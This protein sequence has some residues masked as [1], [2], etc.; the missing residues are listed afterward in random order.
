MKADKNKLAYIGAKPGTN[1]Q[2]I[3]DSDAWFTPGIYTEMAR[4]VMGEI[5]LDPF[6]SAA[7][8]RHVK[9]KRYFDI[10]S[11]AFEKVWFQDQGRVFMN[12]PYGRKLINASVDI[13]LENW[14][15]KSILQAVVLVNNATETKWFQSLLRS[16]NSLCMP[17]RR[18]SF[19]A[20]DGKNVSGNTRGQVFFYFGNKSSKFKKVFKSVGVILMTDVSHKK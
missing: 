18:I 16:A 14:K 2:T 11:N 13:F 15:N 20:V 1:K 12:P 7:A 10:N 4:E 17:D 8:N 6:S 3:R 5:E 19:E 9:A